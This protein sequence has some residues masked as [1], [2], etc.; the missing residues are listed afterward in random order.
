MNNNAILR[1]IRYVFDY[2]DAKMLALFGHVACQVS[3]E[4]LSAWLK[5]D[6]DP[7]FQACR[8]P[9]LA[10]FL[11][12]LIIER[13]GKKAGPVPEPERRLTNNIIFKKLKVALDLQSDQVL[14]LLELAGMPLSQ[15]EL[16][17]LFRKP[18]HKH[19]RL[20]KD[21]ILRNFLKGVQLKYRPGTTETDADA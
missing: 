11:N 4:Q 1:R 20:C 7:A 6:D 19:Y 5:K 2:G 9:E 13:R 16:S 12:G 15:H 21:Q 18:G 8:D 14:E 17:A 3:R 10:S